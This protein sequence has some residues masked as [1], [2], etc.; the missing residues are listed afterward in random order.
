VRKPRRRAAVVRL[1]SPRWVMR[2]AAVALGRCRAGTMPRWVMRR[3]AAALP[4]SESDHRLGTGRAM[5]GEGKR[6]DRP[7]DGRGREA[8][9]PTARWKRKVRGRGR[10]REEE[11]GEES[12][13]V[14]E[15]GESAAL[16]SGRP[17][18]RTTLFACRRWKRKRRV[19]AARRV[20]VEKRKRN[21]LDAGGRPLAALQWG[22]RTGMDWE[23]TRCSGRGMDWVTG[24]WTR[25]GY[26][27]I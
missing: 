21:R 14:E 11:G 15:E 13:R 27:I 12:N 18:K 7:R 26:A 23:W 25:T 6:W 22:R 16:K 4:S 3:P 2:R 20:A 19:R 5:E 1:W 8:L 9:E 17:W 24:T 10:G